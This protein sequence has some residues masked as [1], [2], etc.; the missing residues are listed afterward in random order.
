LRSARRDSL[1]QP[2]FSADSAIWLRVLP[3]LGPFCCFSGRSSISPPK[4]EYAPSYNTSAVDTGDGG[5]EATVVRAIVTDAI[6]LNM[7]MGSGVVWGFA[8][9]GR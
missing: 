8:S 7:E 6:R 2:R 1:W 5:A 3:F 4:V 9:E